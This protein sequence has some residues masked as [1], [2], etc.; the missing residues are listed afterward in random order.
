MPKI[1]KERPNP[2]GRITKAVPVEPYLK[3]SFR[4]ASCSD[5]LFCLSKCGDGYLVKL[6][7]RLNSLCGL[8]VKEFMTNRSN[9]LRAH[10]IDWSRTSR[11]RGFEH[12]NNQLQDLEPW[13]FEV[14]SN[15][16]GRIHGLI[17]DDT[18]YIVWFDPLHKLYA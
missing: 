7:E 2:A 3:F 6:V 15:K 5:G 14:T 18:F 13:Q 17:L 12:L 11:S 9:A 4:Y 16:H 10:K 1:T 8:T